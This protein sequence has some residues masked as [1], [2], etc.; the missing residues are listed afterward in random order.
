MAEA[1]KKLEVVPPP[2]NQPP[3]INT[4][5]ARLPI[6]VASIFGILCHNPVSML[7]PQPVAAGK[8]KRVYDPVEEAAAACYVLQDGSYGFPGIGFRNSMLEAAKAFKIP[9]SRASMAGILGHIMVE[10]D[11]VPL[12]DWNGKPLRSYEIDRRRVVIKG[13]GVIHSRPFFPQWSAQFEIVYDPQ[14]VPSTDIFFEIANDA[15]ARVGV[16]DY[17][18]QKKGW[19]G[20]FAV[21]PL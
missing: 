8:K 12:L 11:L 16:G 21:W 13:N 9:R 19:F 7:D 3:V 5:F 18:P 14:L 1:K 15:G 4:T 2:S 10:P 20:R 6:R 17:R